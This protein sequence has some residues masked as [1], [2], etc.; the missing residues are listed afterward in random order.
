M[1]TRAC[2]CPNEPDAR[3][4][5]DRERIVDE[6]TGKTAFT[7]A[8]PTGHWHCTSCGRDVCPPSQHNRPPEELMY[9]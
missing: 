9:L 3:W 8:L 7:V 5:P 2:Q 1:A 6:L 4:V